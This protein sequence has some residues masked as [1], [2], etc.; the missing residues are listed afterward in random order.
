[1]SA[2]PG[3]KSA[4]QIAKAQMKG[5]G[6][7]DEERKTAAEPGFELEGTL[8]WRSKTDPPMTY[9]Y[10][11][12]LQPFG[13]VHDEGVQDPSGY[14]RHHTGEPYAKYMYPNGHYHEGEWRVN[15]RHGYGVI[16]MANGYRIE[17]RFVDDQPTGK[18]GEI[19]TRNEYL[20]CDHYVAGKPTREGTIFYNPR[21][22][23]TYRYQGGFNRA[24]KKHDF[25]KVFY[26]NGD[27]FIGCWKE[28]KRHGKAV[29]VNADG[30]RFLS[31]WRD[32]KLVD[33]PREVVGDN[34]EADQIIKGVNVVAKKDKSDAQAGGQEEEEEAMQWGASAGYAPADLTKWRVQD[35]VTDLSLEHFH[36]L[37]AGF[38]KLDEDY[39]GE[40]SMAELTRLWGNKDRRMLMR[41]DR[42]KDGQ[43]SLYEVLLEW[44]PDVRKSQLTRFTTIEPDIR[45]V[46]RMRGAMAGIA[47][48]SQDGFFQLADHNDGANLS[49]QSLAAHKDYLGGE[50]VSQIMWARASALHD[51][52]SFVDVLEAW[53][54][55]TPRVI[56]ERFNLSRVAYDELEA[57]Y[58]DF[59]AL[60]VKGNGCVDIQVMAEARAK[61]R[62]AMYHAGS[63]GNVALSSHST[64]ETEHTRM[65]ESLVSKLVPFFFKA[66]PCWVIGSHIKL[67]VPMLEQ[68]QEWC[69]RNYMPRSSSARTVTFGDLMRYSFANLPCHHQKAYL[70]KKQLPFLCTCDV[71]AFCRNKQIL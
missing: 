23:P 30:R 63:G 20:K 70:L 29:T 38:E 26:S 61:K 42:N 17:G 59:K 39:S 69:A 55:N 41:L 36:R 2:T 44:Y 24:G 33:G 15:K 64:M 53:C 14:M 50:H 43:V 66:D 9:G 54:P 57:C 19:F 5:G 45:S 71:C 35:G 16:R 1:M 58:T 46:W 37:N 34:E 18:C 13:P 28:G 51:P 22:D 52:P 32:D 7:R 21:E 60:D 10:E 47:H 8:E 67:T 4:F 56:L 62:E 31:Q 3:R 11:G 49:Q 68:V 48:P 27:V 40:L 6:V 25:G 12:Q 65:I